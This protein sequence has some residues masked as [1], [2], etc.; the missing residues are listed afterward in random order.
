MQSGIERA[1]QLAGSNGCACVP[2]R[3]LHVCVSMAACLFVCCLILYFLFP[4]SVTLTP[5]S[6]LSVMVY[7]SPDQVKLDVKVSNSKTAAWRLRPLRT[8]AIA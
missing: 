6:V 4:R 1:R 5:V 2:F 7:F 8:S 3:K